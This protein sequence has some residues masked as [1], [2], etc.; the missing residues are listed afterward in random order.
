MK[1]NIIVYVIYKRMFLIY[2]GIYVYWLIKYRIE[3]LF[4]HNNCAEPVRCW[5]QQNQNKTFFSKKLFRVDIL[6]VFMFFSFD[7][8]IKIR[9]DYNKLRVMCQVFFWFL[10]CYKLK[11]YWSKFVFF[12]NYFYIFTDLKLKKISFYLFFYSF[13][14]KKSSQHVAI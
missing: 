6:V 1:Y 4:T 7:F 11:F 12:F 2:S 13:I 5:F 3:F 10:Y 8:K 9:K 14:R